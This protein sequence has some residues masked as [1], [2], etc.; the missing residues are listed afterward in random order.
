MVSLSPSYLCNMQG[1]QS[2]VNGATDALLVCQHLQLKSTV[3]F[4]LQLLHCQPYFGEIYPNAVAIKST[5]N[6]LRN[7]CADFALKHV[8]EMHPR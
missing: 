3:Y 7:S 5:D 2:K 6:D 1:R 4:R 8:G